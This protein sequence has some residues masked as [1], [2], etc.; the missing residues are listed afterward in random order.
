MNCL[1]A[2]TPLKKWEGCSQSAPSAM[3]L[4]LHFSLSLFT[5]TPSLSPSQRS[6]KHRALR[7]PSATPTLNT[8]P[9]PLP[10]P[11]CKHKNKFTDS[12]PVTSL[13][14]ARFFPCATTYCEQVLLT[15]KCGEEFST[16]TGRTVKPVASDQRTPAS[17]TT[18]AQ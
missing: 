18:I 12:R 3:H 1:P 6:N 17:V 10:R 14:T 13:S 7:A 9:S 8:Y 2:A 15:Y 5:Y 16:S 11:P 4:R